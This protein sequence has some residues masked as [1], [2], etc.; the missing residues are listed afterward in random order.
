MDRFPFSPTPNMLYIVFMTEVLSKMYPRSFA[1]CISSPIMCQGHY[2][3]NSWKCKKP[4]PL[5]LTLGLS[6]LEM[7]LRITHFTYS[8]V[9][10]KTEQIGEGNNKQC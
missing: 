8:N 10:A 9:A 6:F 7:L 2:T 1:V 5:L 3:F 4:T